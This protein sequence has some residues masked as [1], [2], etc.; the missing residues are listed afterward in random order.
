M[1]REITFFPPRFPIVRVP[2]RYR[3]ASDVSNDSGRKISGPR[4]LGTSTVGH[5]HLIRNLK[6]GLGYKTTLDET[7][8]PQHIAFE[9]P[10]Q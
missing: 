9:T 4:S 8:I 1:G 3:A 2:M 10:H 5:T 6:N 7:V